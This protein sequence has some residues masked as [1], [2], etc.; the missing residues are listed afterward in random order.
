MSVIRRLKH[1]TAIL[2]VA[3]VATAGLAAVAAYCDHQSYVWEKPPQGITPHRPGPV[4]ITIRAT[5]SEQIWPQPKALFIR[6]GA[7]KGAIADGPLIAFERLLGSTGL[8]V[9]RLLRE[10]GNS[11][12]GEGG[13]YIA[14][15]GVRVPQLNHERLSEL[16]QFTKNLPLGSPLSAYQLSSG[17]GARIDPIKHD[18]AFHPGLD[19][20]APYR[21]T[22]Y[23]AGQ[24]TVSF[25]G[26]MDGYGRV[27]EIDHGHGIITRYAHLHRILVA[28]GQR[29]GGHAV[30]GELGSTGRS[31]GPH[32][33]YEIRVAGVPLDPDKF[34][35]FG[36]NAVQANGGDLKPLP[37]P[38][39]ASVSAR[40]L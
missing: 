37:P 20:V 7:Q 30:I 2:L 3:S 27:V 40:P 28:E 35:Q 26:S 13:P 1:N 11:S 8:D 25:A 22:V 12:A 19:M 21:S 23:S 29:V 9:E 33:H 31:T 16:K 6:V 18:P 24:G 14:L 17:F 39:G 10:L 34:I 36:E 4:P 32:L 5:Y 38:V 15:N